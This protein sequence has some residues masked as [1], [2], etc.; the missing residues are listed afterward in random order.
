MSFPGPSRCSE[1]L[2]VILPLL[3]SDHMS[4][5]SFFLSLPLLLHFSVSW[6]QTQS[7]IH[8]LTLPIFPQGWSHFLHRLTFQMIKLNVS[9]QHGQRRTSLQLGHMLRCLSKELEVQLYCFSNPQFSYPLNE[10]NNYRN[11]FVPSVATAAVSED[12]FLQ[13][14][15]QIPQG[16]R[17]AGGS[18]MCWTRFGTH[19]S[20]ALHHRLGLWRTHESCC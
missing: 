7:L 14:S 1:V 20:W 9:L 8:Y 5:C 13:Q 17:C 6:E 19:S 16:G 4:V 11:H 12:Q 18:K 3:F 10:N 15:L 2:A